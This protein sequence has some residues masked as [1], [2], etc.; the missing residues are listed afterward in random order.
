M[1]YL[2]IIAEDAIAEARVRP[3]HARCLMADVVGVVCG[4][5]VVP[6]ALVVVAYASAETMG[7]IEQDL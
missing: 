5:A 2:G 6:A 4:N 7:V 1:R 3:G